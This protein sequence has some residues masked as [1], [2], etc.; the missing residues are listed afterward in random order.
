M[1]VEQELIAIISKRRPEGPPILPGT[2]LADLG[3]DSLDLIEVIFEVEEKFDI[4]MRQSNEEAAKADLSDLC[5]WIEEARAA[6]GK[7]GHASTPSPS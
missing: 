4:Q 1:N 2:K 7:S 6:K 3:I 5:R